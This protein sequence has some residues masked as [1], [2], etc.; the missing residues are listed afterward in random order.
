MKSYSVI[1]LFSYSIIQLFLLLSVQVHA[2]KGGKVTRYETFI[3]TNDRLSSIIEGEEKTRGIAGDFLRTT[4]AAART[5]S[6][7]FISAFVDMGI[8]AVSSLLTKSEEDQKKWEEIVAA[9]NVFLEVL[10]TEYSINDFYSTTSSK[11]PMDPLG[12]KFDGIGCLRK[13]GADTVFYI[14]CRINREKLNRIIEHSKFELLL[15][16]LIIN[17]YE[18]NL[19]NSLFD[20]EFSFD[21]RKDLRISLDITIVSSWINMQTML[22]KEQV[23]GSFS[24]NIPVSEKDLNEKKQL[25]YVRTAGKPELYKIEGESFIVPRS[26]MG[27]RNAKGEYHDSWGTGEYSV[28]IV[29]REKCNVTESYRENWKNDFKARQKAAQDGAFL[30][31][32][33]KVVKTQVWDRESKKWIITTIKAPVNM[34]QEDINKALGI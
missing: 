1:Q 32:V 16:T 4:A 2:Q 6:G 5:G 31:R 26:Y 24:L 22:Q 30:D 34:M 10:S 19:P 29:L 21:R 8:G 3:Y 20:P 12:M 17:P 7:G 23:L 27:Y 28:N 15:D 11:S 13:S 33:W 25:R 9:E 14:S 18:C